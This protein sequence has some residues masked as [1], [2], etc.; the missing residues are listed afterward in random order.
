MANQAEVLDVM[1][2]HPKKWIHDIL[3]QIAHHGANLCSFEISHY[4]PVILHLEI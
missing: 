2:H 4:I 1:L 3:A